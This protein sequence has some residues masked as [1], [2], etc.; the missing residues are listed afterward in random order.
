MGD[1][2][3]N[4]INIKD[5]KLDSLRGNLAYVTQDVQLFHAAIRDNLTLFESKISD[6]AILNALDDIGLSEWIMSMPEGL[7][8]ILDSE[9]ASLSTGEA[10]LM[11]FIR[12]FLKDPGLVILD[13]AS[14]RLDPITEKYME[15]AIDKLL[16]NRSCIMIAHR[17]STLMRADDILILDN[18]EVVEYGPREKL[19]EDENSKYY[20]L[21]QKGI[22]EVLV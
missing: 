18:G 16:K 4:D 11:A 1:I 13:E 3:I 17:L 12:V 21:L 2:L 19:L 14:S 5:I 10:Q 15:N 7:D 8:T 22:E 6:E 9:G 20:K